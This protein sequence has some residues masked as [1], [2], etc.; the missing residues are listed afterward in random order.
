MEME[1]PLYPWQSQL[2]CIT[3]TQVP[4]TIKIQLPSI[5]PTFL[6]GTTELPSELLDVLSLFSPLFLSFIYLL[7]L[8]RRCPLFLF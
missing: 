6:P 2:P 7:F 4:N 8:T 5:L 1:L 3:E